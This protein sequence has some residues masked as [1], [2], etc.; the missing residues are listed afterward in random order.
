MENK[1]SS[2]NVFV[3]LKYDQ[4]EGTLF[5]KLRTYIRRGG[6]AFHIHVGMYVHTQL[7]ACTTQQA[8]ECCCAN[9]RELPNLSGIYYICSSISSPLSQRLSIDKCDETENSGG[10]WYLGESW[11]GMLLLI[12][13]Q[14]QFTIIQG[15]RILCWVIFLEWKIYNVL[16]FHDGKVKTAI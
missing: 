13:D 7:L 15:H 12:I 1:Y 6:V 3:F 16:L 5:L 9:N 8:R 10:D 4:R 11:V 14:R 2:K